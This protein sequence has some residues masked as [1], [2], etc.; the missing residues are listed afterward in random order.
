M[1]CEPFTTILCAD[2]SDNSFTLS[3][4]AYLHMHLAEIRTIPTMFGLIAAPDNAY[5]KQRL[6]YYSSRSSEIGSTGRPNQVHQFGSVWRGAKMLPVARLCFQDAW[7]SD[8]TTVEPPLWRACLSLRTS[9]WL[10][11]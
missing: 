4:R 6:L 11:G 8:Q 7:P 9:V 5:P 1:W 3:F 2:D 10:V